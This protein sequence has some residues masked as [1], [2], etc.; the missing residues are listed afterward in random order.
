MATAIL[1]NIAGGTERIEG[2]IPSGLKTIT[3]I[4]QFCY[5]YFVFHMV[6]QQ[7]NY[8]YLCWESELLGRFKIWLQFVNHSSLLKNFPKPTP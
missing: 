6:I 5:L 4:N 7:Q 2:L 1:L 3:Q 8:R